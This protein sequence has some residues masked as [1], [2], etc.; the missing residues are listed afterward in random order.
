MSCS[1]TGSSMC[2]RQRGVQHGDAE[3]TIAGLEP[4]RGLALEGVHV[5]AHRE[6]LAGPA[7]ERDPV[8]LAHPVAR[9]VD[10]LAVDEHVPVADELAGLAAAGA[11]SSPEDDVVEAQFEV[12]QEV[13]AG[14]AGLATRLLVEIAE[15]LLQKAVDP[16][17][18]LL[19]AE[20]GQ[21]LRPL[22]HAVTPVLAGRV[23]AAVTIRHRLGDGALERVAALAFQEQLGPLAPAETADGSGVSRHKTLPLDLDP[24]PLLGAAAVVGDGGDVLDADNFD[25][26]GSE[27]PDSRLTT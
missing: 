22:P 3:A 11:P 15:L 1:C 14:D 23:G 21:V 26:H 2:S 4:G 8:P 24:T 18:L 20:L 16:A 19:F 17:C 12:A 7:L 27:R 25:A 5:A 13:L 10:A 9:D 6:V